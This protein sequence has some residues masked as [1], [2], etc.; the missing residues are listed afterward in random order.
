MKRGRAIYDNIVKFVRF[1]L[2][3]TLGFALL[4][5]GASISDVAGGKPFAAIAVLWV[6]LV[7]DGPPAMALGLDKPDRDVM[8]RKPRPTTERILTR[9]RWVAV[10]FASVIM[11]GGTLAVLILAPGAEPKAGVATVAGT[12]AFNTFV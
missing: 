6:N 12:I 5:L 2:S 8:Q 1:Q 9:S 3:P 10:S 7:M 4:F 11:A